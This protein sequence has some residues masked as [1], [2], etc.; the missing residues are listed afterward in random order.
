[1]GIDTLHVV[2][3]THWDREW[4]QA[5]QHF[6][7]R[8]VYMMDELLDKLEQDPAYKHFMLDG[9]TIIV[10]DYLEIRPENAER[11]I[12]FIRSG[13]IEVGPWYVM[14]DE[15]LVSGESL[16]RNLLLGFRKARY[17]GSE[18]MKSGLV[19]DTF[20]HIGQ[21]PQLLRGFGIDNAVLFRGFYGD[22]E[23]SEMLWAGPDGSEVLGLKLDEDRSYSDFFFFMRWPFSRRNYEY[24]SAELIERAKEML[25]YKERRS[26]VNIALGLDGVDHVEIEPRLPWMLDVLNG[27][28]LQAKFEHGSLSSY[29]EALREKLKDVPLKRYYGERRDPGHNGYNNW[30][31]ANVLSSRIHLKQLNQRCETSL[32]RWAEPW[33]VFGSLE[34]LKYP[35]GFLAKSWKY[36]LQNHPHDSI[37]GC[38]IDQVHRDMQYRFDQSLLISE[39][40]AEERLVY[41]MNHIS[42]DS[43]RNGTADGMLT[44]FNASQLPI[45]GITVMELNL[46]SGTDAAIRFP[47]LMG[48]SFRIHDADGKEVPYQLLDIQRDSVR[49]IRPYRDV[50]DAE[51]VDR[52]RVAMHAK[53]PSSGYAAYTYVQNEMQA[54]VYGQYNAPQM[55]HPVRHSGT[56]QTEVHA[57]DN[58]HYELKIRPNGTFDLTD[59]RTGKAY[60]ELL[61]FEDESDIGDG[62]SHVP[63]VVNGAYSSYG[64]SAQ[65][66]VLQNGPLV[67][68]I[69][70]ETL[71]LVPAE[72][73]SGAVR[74]SDSRMPLPICTVLELRK[75]DPLLRIRTTVRNEVRDH[76]LSALFPTGVR[77]ETYTTSTPFELVDRPILRPD[78][79]KSLNPD[80]ETVPHNGLVYLHD[81]ES[82]FALFSNGLY[83]TAVRSDE[84]RSI[85]LT[86]F[87]STR[88]EVLT[89]GGDGGQLLGDL[90]FE[91]GVRMFG[92]EDKAGLYAEAMR[93]RAG[94]RVL[95]R[96]IGTPLLETPH[97]READLPM[98][99]SYLELKGKGLC[100]SAVKS[101]EDDPGSV[102]IRCF[103]VTNDFVTGSLLLSRELFHAELVNLDEQY[104]DTVEWT[105]NQIRLQAGPHQI[106][107]VKLQ[108]KL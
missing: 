75:D 44:I 9:Q 42:A 68:L 81:D 101:A 12:G 28:G 66:S 98:C 14:P 27:A 97:V 108:F 76:R 84:S 21:L 38:S 92:A 90:T 96:S 61:Q 18:P 50:P 39:A 16:I 86:L 87:R 1:M 49:R 93:A 74:R 77:S 107:T 67:A 78:R 63:S 83:E 26:T 88:K 36:L 73:P 46:P 60:R 79:S 34:G 95:Q 22:A 37:C 64:V 2:S 10:D 103:N 5:F 35:S 15:F 104:A 58:G 47:H 59:I 29:L 106:I 8:L 33:A 65:I 43:V 17:W 100:L 4:Y 105:V 80:R 99:R 32:E 70:I 41:L 52:F 13:R 71:L 40:M 56:M 54:P 31:P 6:R 23:P 51:M 69:Q 11:L 19:N 20:G 25:V 89:D 24:D 7:I 55:S 102:I 45:D 30:T 53:V 62:W 72:T 48:T 94:I 91:Y 82:G 85:A 3:H 57:W